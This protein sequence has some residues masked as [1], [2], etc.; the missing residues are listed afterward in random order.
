MSCARLQISSSQVPSQARASG[1]DAGSTSNW[2]DRPP[3]PPL[4]RT[5][6]LH[7]RRP[8]ARFARPRGVHRPEVAAHPASR[9]VVDAQRLRPGSGSRRFPRCRGRRSHGVHQG[10]GAFADLEP[11]CRIRRGPQHFSS[12]LE[13]LSGHRPCE[14]PTC[15]NEYQ[16]RILDRT[17]G[18]SLSTRRVPRFPLNRREK[19][20]QS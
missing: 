17:G 19:R 12:Q 16:Q 7:H 6:L 14:T 18:R 11:L 20:Y 15:G 5:R 8:G 10:E 9:R 2:I 1:S 3:R 13:V 4:G